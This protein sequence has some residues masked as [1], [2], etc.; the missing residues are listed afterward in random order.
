MPLNIG[1]FIT[2]GKWVLKMSQGTPM[3]EIIPRNTDDTTVQV[4]N[5]GA[6]LGMNSASKCIDQLHA[7]CKHTK[8]KQDVM[9]YN[10]FSWSWFDMERSRTLPITL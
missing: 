5:I 6:S 7:I 9:R 8:G 1:H 4:K 3:D 2:D 10:Y